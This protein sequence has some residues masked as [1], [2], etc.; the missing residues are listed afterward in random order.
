MN[1]FWSFCYNLALSLWIG[2]ISIF[3]FMVTPV[4]FKSFDRDMAGSIVGKLFPGYF[5][6]NTVLSVV[7]LILLQMMRPLLMRSGFKLSLFLVVSAIVINIFIVFKLHPDAV[8]VKREIHSFQ[9]PADDTPLRKEFRKLHAVSS[10]LNLLLL[11]D[12]VTLLVISILK[13]Q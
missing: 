12:G 8:K 4:I 3:T 6:Y 1:N 11:A 5:I 13:K 10:V 7:V 9:T 2:G